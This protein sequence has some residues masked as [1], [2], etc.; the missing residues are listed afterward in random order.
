MFESLRTRK[1]RA[2][3]HNWNRNDANC[4]LDDATVT[5]APTLWIGV[6]FAAQTVI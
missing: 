6:R 2:C 1:G 3:G 4:S 5:A